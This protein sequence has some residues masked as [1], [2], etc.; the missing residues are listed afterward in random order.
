MHEPT[1]SFRPPFCPFPECRFHTDPQGWRFKKNGCH[2]RAFDR[3]R[4]QRYRCHHCRR[5]FS[6]QTFST[7]YWL[8][9][10]DLLLP[11]L[12]GLLACSAYRQLARAHL[13]SPTTVAR[14][15]ARLGRHALLFHEVHRPQGPPREPIVLDGFETFEFSQYWPT[16]LN[17]VVGA[18]S[19]FV[20]ATTVAELRRKGRM[21]AHQKRRRAALE[22]RYGRPDPRAIE[23]SAA[24]ALALAVPPG[25]VEITLR[26][27]DHR[28]YPRALRR[29]P[30][31]RFRHEVTSSRVPRTARNPLFA[32]NL[33]HGL[34]RHGGANHK[35]ETIAWSKRNQSMLWRDAVHRVWRNWA[36]HVSERKRAGSPAMRLGLARRLLRWAE[37]LGRRLFVT[38]IALPEPIGTYYAGRVPT[39]QIPNARAHRLKLAR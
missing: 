21:T 30:D 8:K 39:R 35:R 28:A 14:Q 27:D 24:R 18:E 17:T 34:M 19:H 36:K 1:A 25:P 26:S 16:H 23:Q 2:R 9:R 22:A 4:I 37:I 31:R 3:R 10:P 33:L 15:A 6:T 29:L 20:Y 38:R 13:V 5:S 32:V 7:T 11:V 12:H